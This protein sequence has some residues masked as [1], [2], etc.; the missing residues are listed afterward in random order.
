METVIKAILE[1]S[2]PWAALCIFLVWQ[3]L[4]M[5]KRHENGLKMSIELLRKGMETHEIAVG[6]RF[7]RL[8]KQTSANGEML[9]DCQL[10]LHVSPARR[11]GLDGHGNDS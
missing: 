7:D 3:L 1:S 2:G 5:V 10:K 4:E 8:D 6:A 11:G 9:R